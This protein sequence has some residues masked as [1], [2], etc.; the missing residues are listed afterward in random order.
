M[1][2]A[3]CTDS[4]FVSALS[5][6][7]NNHLAS[8]VSNSWGGPEDSDPLFIPIYH[9]DLR[10]PARPRA[11]GSCSPPG[12][13]ATSRRREAAGH[14]DQIQV[15][16]PTSDPLVTSVGGTSLAIGKSRNYLFETSWGTLLNPL[17]ASGKKWQFPLPGPYPAGFDG[18]SGG[19]TSTLFAPPAYQVGPVPAALSQRLPSGRTAEHPMRV[20][21]DVA[22]Y[23]DPATGFLVGQTVRLPHGRGF[24]FALSRIGGTSVA[25]P[26]FAGIQADAQQEARHASWASPTR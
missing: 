2:A 10:R 9:P 7:V 11:S 15:D 25:C 19:G 8:I 20:V 6:I 17:A 22:A 24:G 3:S 18:G 16:Y 4:D 14:L 21:P 13:T 12:T 1:A 23:A 5:L 26:T